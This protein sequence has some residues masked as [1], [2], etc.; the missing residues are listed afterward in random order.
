MNSFKIDVRLEGDKFYPSKLQ[1]KI[2]IPL[3]ILSEYG[4]IG[5][6]G[7]Y[8]GKI[9]PF[10]MAV[11]QFPTYKKDINDSLYECYTKLL[12][13]KKMMDEC[14][15][16]DIIIDI[17]NFEDYPLNVTFSKEI[18]ANLNSLNAT[19]EFHTVAKEKK[20][21]EFGERYILE[22]LK[23]YPFVKKDNLQKLMNL[24]QKHP[25]LS[26]TNALS[27]W[28]FLGMKDSSFEQ[29][30]QNHLSEFDAFCESITV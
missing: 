9:S 5:T 21:E 8:A 11:F 4:E 27:Y 12:S 19:V 3:N 15:V 13:W 2:A 22:I 6:K 7:R 18:M 10:G 14:G 24:S 25:S 20:I 30:A 28:L 17:G 16:D 29:E 23:K 26:Q 1:T